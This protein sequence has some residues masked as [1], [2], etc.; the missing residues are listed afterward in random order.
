MRQAAA[1]DLEAQNPDEVGQREL[2]HIEELFAP[3]LLWLQEETG[4]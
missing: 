1:A 3:G 2:R 4:E